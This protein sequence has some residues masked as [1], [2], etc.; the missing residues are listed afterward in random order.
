VTRQ[1]RLP[2][3][4]RIE[5]LYSHRAFPKLNGLA[6]E[7]RFRSLFGL[8]H[9]VAKQIYP[10]NDVA[11]IPQDADFVLRHLQPPCMPLTPKAPYRQTSGNNAASDDE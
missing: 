3:K 6:I 1:L 8:L 4:R 11:V 7:K 9:V 10:A 5:A 2:L